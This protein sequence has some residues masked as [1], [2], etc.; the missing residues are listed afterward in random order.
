MQET[1]YVKQKTHVQIKVAAV[2]VK[3]EST[4]RAVDSEKL[5][6]D[7]LPDS[8]KKEKNRNLYIYIH[9]WRLKIE[10]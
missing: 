7:V 8:L 10:S 2:S 5:N 9:L 1:V 4:E 3:M 6:P